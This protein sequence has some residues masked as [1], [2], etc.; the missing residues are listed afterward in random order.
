MTEEGGES[1]EVDDVAEDDVQQELS[2]RQTDWDEAVE[3]E[4]GVDCRD[5]KA[6]KKGTIITY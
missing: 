1:T 6:Y 2:Q 3:E 4:E 5:S